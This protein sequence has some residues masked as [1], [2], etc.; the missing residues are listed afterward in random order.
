MPLPLPDDPLVSVIHVAVVVAVQL[1]P[2]AADTV[3][4]PV[5]AVDGGLADDG[6]TVGEQVAPDWFTVK[7]APPTDT[8]PVRGVVA[9]FAATV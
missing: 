2:V 3:M 6:E 5:P 1:H 8:V 9:V 7:V 4:V